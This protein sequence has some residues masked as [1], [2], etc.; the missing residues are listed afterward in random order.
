MGGNFTTMN[1]GGITIMEKNK[2]T[3]KEND[4]IYLDGVRLNFVTDY[5][6]ESVAQGFAE[7]KITLV[8]DDSEMFKQN[9][10][11]YNTELNS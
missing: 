9:S 1:T 11:E 6:L 3:F 4:G 7:L 8:V 5:K 2:I 10:Y